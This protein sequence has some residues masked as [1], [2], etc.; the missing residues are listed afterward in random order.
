MI[1]VYNAVCYDG[2]DAYVIKAIGQNEEDVKEV[3]EGT[4]LEVLKV[5]FLHSWEN[6]D[7]HVKGALRGEWELGGDDKDLQLAIL[8]YLEQKTGIFLRGWT[9]VHSLFV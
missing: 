1:N 5:D 4:D 6:I 8:R 7:E 3:F 2:V 9:S